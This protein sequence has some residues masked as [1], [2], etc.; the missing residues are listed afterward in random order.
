MFVFPTVQRVT[1]ISP[2]VPNQL[3]AAAPGL[4]EDEEGVCQGSAGVQPSMAALQWKLHFF[5][6]KE[7]SELLDF[8]GD[9]RLCFLASC[10]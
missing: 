8:R 7:T 3:L 2:V 6:S 10:S 1:I 4:E 9:I 5:Q